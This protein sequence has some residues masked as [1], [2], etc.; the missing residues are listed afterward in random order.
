MGGKIKI[1]DKYLYVEQYGDPSNEAILYLHGGPGASCLDFCHYQAKA[2]SEYFLVITL[3]QRGVLRSEPLELDESFGIDD[4]IRDFE[5]L[6]EHF[7]IRQWNLIGHSFGGYLA[8][9]YAYDY[10][11]SIK[12][13]IYEAPSFDIAM[14]SRS[15]FLKA[16][17]LLDVNDLESI[18]ECN[19]F[20][21]GNYNASELLEAWGLVSKKLEHNR[22][23][24]YFHENHL[25]R[26]IIFDQY[27]AELWEKTYIHSIKLFQEGK[28]NNS[29][30][31]YLEKVNHPSLLIHG[32]YDPVCCNQQYEEFINKSP[33]RKVVIFEQSAHMPRLEEPTKYTEVVTEFINSESIINEGRGIG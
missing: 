8:L 31:A 11:S 29:L 1:R 32:K 21:N 10:P 6:R 15:L 16:L 22:E 24:I 3:D 5:T 19:R 7:K 2:L 25:E 4:L 33:N 17:D 26:D 23:L 13:I 12:R 27:P 20:I 18:A 30:I 28:I 14:S 9:K